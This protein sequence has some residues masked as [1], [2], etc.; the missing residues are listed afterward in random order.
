M[1]LY[2]KIIGLSRAFTI[3]IPIVSILCGIIFRNIMGI[4][5]GLYVILCDGINHYV[6][7]LFKKLYGNKSSYP[8]LGI[9]ER[10]NGARHCG[11]FIYEHD[12][13]GIPTSY[14]MPSGHSQMATLT[15]TFL[16]M[17]L[18]NTFGVNLYNIISIGI[19]LFIC[20]GILYSR[21]HLKCHTIQQI[22][23]GGLMGILYGIIGY[24][25]YKKVNEFII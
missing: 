23:V 22:I 20:I 1:S 5:L 12:L 21:F 16:I 13:E 4:F 7:I 17:Y 11:S 25:I 24:Y 19:I 6:K 3:I 8:I 15:A 18:L 2:Y 9:G 10:P 14:G